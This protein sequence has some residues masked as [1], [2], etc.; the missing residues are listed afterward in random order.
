MHETIRRRR[1]PHWDL[2]DAA[3]LV[4]TCLAGSIP[5]QGLLDIERYRVDLERRP[6]PDALP[7]MEWSQRIDKLVFARRDSWLDNQAAVRHLQDPRLAQAVVDAFYY[8]A[9]QRYD[10]LDFVVMPSHIHWVFQPLREWVGTL[11][12]CPTDR[13]VGDTSNV[14]SPRQRIQ[15]SINRHTALECNR[16]LGRTGIFWQRESYDHWVRDA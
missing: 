14:P 15:H 7:E 11:E 5:A 1:L 9:G 16:L 12:T 2:P 8:F 4:T 10:L 3:Y 13:S 6:K